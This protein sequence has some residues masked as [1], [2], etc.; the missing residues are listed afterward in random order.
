MTREASEDFDFW[1]KRVRGARPI[2]FIYADFGVAGPF[3]CWTGV[4]PRIWGGVQW[5]GSGELLRFSNPKESMDRQRHGIALELAS[6]DYFNVK[7]HIQTALNVQVQG[8]P[9]T[10]W[11]GFIDDLGNT[12]NDPLVYFSGHISDMKILQDGDGGTSIRV[13]GEHEMRDLDRSQR[14]RVTMSSQAL[15]DPTDKGLQYLNEVSNMKA[16]F[17]SLYAKRV[18][19]D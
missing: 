8:K 14:Y 6:T 10:I 4:G 13:E 15:V 5:N 12:V 9:L 16:N 1:T 7:D 2:W 18:K 19:E 17:G 3:R 11:Q